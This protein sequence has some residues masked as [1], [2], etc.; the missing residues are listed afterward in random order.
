MRVL[1]TGGNGF[2]GSALVR[3][4][5][6]DT[7]WT[8][9]NVD[10]LSLGSSRRAAEVPRRRGGYVHELVDIRDCV[11]LRGV[12]A[13]RQPDGI[14]HLAAE[15]HVDR[16]IDGPEPFITTNIVGT[17]NLLQVAREYLATA[18]RRRRE[19][20]RFLHVSTDEVFGSLAAHEPRFTEASP[21]R[22]SSPYAASKAAADHL[23]LAW[24]RTFGLPVVVTN[25]SNNYGPFQFPEKL[26]PVLILSGLEGRPLPIY[27]QGLNVRDWL[28]VDDH[29]A[30]LLAAFKRGRP[31]QSY[32]FGGNAER[33]NIDVAEAVCALLDEL[34]P[35][36]PHCPHQRLIR[37]V[38]DRPGHDLRYA[39][40]TRKA[41]DELDWKPTVDFRQGL[42]RTVAWYL[43]NGAWC[44]SVRSLARVGE[45]LGLAQGAR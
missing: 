19:R 17:Y 12:L 10:N 27:G 29:A 36:S 26:I 24:Q 3:A 41:R 39:V 42:R 37:L 11:A 20:F 33:R 18:P 2:I 43:D 32:N 6:R 15:S 23:A 21:Y 28:Y 25:C 16:S 14:I 45:R 22:P 40:N 31:G 1:V 30:G 7:D 35:D 5:G 9:V 4:I 44:E 13:R 38:D 8:V 34:R